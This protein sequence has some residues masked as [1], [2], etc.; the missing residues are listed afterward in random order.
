MTL[1]FVGG[2]VL[3][4]GVL[5][6]LAALAQ[7]ATVPDSAT[8]CVDAPYVGYGCSTVSYERPNYGRTSLIGVAVFFI[9]GG[10]FT[11]GIGVTRPSEPGGGTPPD[12][13]GSSATANSR[14]GGD[15]QTLREQLEAHKAGRESATASTAGGRA[16]RK[17]NARDPVAD[18]GAA[19]LV[20]DDRADRSTA[21][22]A[23]AV[24]ADTRPFSPAVPVTVSALVS[25]FVLSWLLS[26]VT[27]V[28]SGGLRTSV[29]ALLSLPGVL[30][31]R[32]YAARRTETDA[33]PEE[34]AN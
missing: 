12:S 3:T 25:A 23:V 10:L 27:V 18:A 21:D 4:L 22:P 2:A 17:S 11:Y 9:F 5:L 19:E 6:L 33:D 8:T 24:D 20:V 28:E 1:K 29:F 16:S 30:V 26:A 34:A 31:Y 14:Q 13:T 7:P 15:P 32:R